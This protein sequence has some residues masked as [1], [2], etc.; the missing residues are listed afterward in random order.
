VS[1][2]QRRREGNVRTGLSAGAGHA[3]PVADAQR[4]YARRRERDSWLRTLPP[5]VSPYSGGHSFTDGPLGCRHIVRRA[6]RAF[7]RAARACWFGE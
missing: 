6:P 5:I 3:Y 7:W 2:S 4:Y 1:C